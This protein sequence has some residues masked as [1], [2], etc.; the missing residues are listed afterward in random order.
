MAYLNGEKIAEKNA[1]D[2]LG[3]DS[4]ATRSHS[5]AKA[6]IFEDVDLSSAKNVLVNGKNVL[7]IQGMNQSLT[8]SDSHFCAAPR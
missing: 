4:I 2:E 6:E 8:N 3:W 7:A 1:P 5:D